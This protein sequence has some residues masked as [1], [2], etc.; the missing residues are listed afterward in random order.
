[1]ER[2]LQ[3]SEEEAQKREAEQQLSTFLSESENLIA[4]VPS[5]HKLKDIARYEVLVRDKDVPDD[6]LQELEPDKKV[7]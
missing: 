5:G 6:N 7:S 3:D 4:R 1:M 2:E